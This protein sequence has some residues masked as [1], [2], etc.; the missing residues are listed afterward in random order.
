FIPLSFCK[1]CLILSRF[2]LRISLSNLEYLEKYYT[3]KGRHPVGEMISDGNS[4]T[5]K[6][7]QMQAFFGLQ[8]TGKLDYSTMD[9]IKRP[10]CGVPDV[11]NYRL[12][13]GEPKW[14]KRTLT[15]R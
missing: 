12:F 11:A 13:P 6:I 9:I 10:R 7:Q 8:V 2:S 5:G 1:F 14:K 4:T 3:P 15:Y